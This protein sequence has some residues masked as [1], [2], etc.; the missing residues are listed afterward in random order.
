MCVQH[1]EVTVV[2]GRRGPV[3]SCASLARVRAADV[4]LHSETDTGKKRKAGTGWE[5]QGRTLGEVLSFKLRTTNELVFQVKGRKN[6]PTEGTACTAAPLVTVSNRNTRRFKDWSS[7][8]KTRGKPTT[9]HSA[10]H[11]QGDS[12]SKWEAQRQESALLQGILCLD[13]VSLVLEMPDEGWL[14]RTSSQLMRWHLRVWCACAL[15]EELPSSLTK[16]GCRSDP[17]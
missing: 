8:G 5:F 17:N 13:W 10:C 14:S 11:R 6:I 16:E 12:K 9:R 4:S 7:D 15:L 2:C 3:W 1:W